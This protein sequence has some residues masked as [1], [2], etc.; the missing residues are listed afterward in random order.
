[1]KKLIATL[2]LSSV[3]LAPAAMASERSDC[4]KEAKQTLKADMQACKTMKGK[5]KK[6]CKSE[7]S[8]KAKEARE[9]CKSKPK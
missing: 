6:E 8:K 2:V 1:M 5:E 9:A 4:M 7:A 3:L